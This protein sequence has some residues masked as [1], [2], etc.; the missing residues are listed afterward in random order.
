VRT[1]KS[2]GTKAKSHMNRRDIPKATSVI[3]NQSNSASKALCGLESPEER[4]QEVE[5]KVHGTN[6]VVME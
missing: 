1:R 4:K 5:S 6:R 3:G 2:G